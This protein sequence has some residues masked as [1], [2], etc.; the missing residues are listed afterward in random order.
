[1]RSWFSWLWI[2]S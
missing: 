2:S 1:M